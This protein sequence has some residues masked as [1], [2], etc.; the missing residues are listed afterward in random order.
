MSDFQKKILIH[1]MRGIKSKNQNIGTYE[2]NKI[3]LSCYD[4]KS[5]ILRN[6]IDTLTYR[7][8]NISFKKEIFLIR[9]VHSI[10]YIKFFFS[11]VI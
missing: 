8:K 7:H 4:D 11:S 10:I 9:L 3:S 6:G 5:Y 2:S 1:K